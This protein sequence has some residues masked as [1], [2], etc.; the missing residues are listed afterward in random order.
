MDDRFRLVFAKTLAIFFEQSLHCLAKVGTESLVRTVP[1][2]NYLRSLVGSIAQVSSSYSVPGIVL[3]L[4]ATDCTDVY[5][6]HLVS[7]NL[8]YV[9]VN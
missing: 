7:D 6:F 9:C 5:P 3:N 4:F 8:Q 1:A 2:K